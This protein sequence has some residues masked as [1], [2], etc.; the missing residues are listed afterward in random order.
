R[1]R[2]PGDADLPCEPIVAAAGGNPRRLIELAREVL[3]VGAGSDPATTGVLQ[4]AAGIERRPAPARMMGRELEALG[5]A[6]AS[7]PVLLDRLGWTRSRAV[8]VL[9]ELEA[10]GVVVGTEVRAGPGRPRKVYRLR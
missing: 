10:A 5:G 2:L 9:K 6:S 8:Q 7:D 1:R 4:R 3:T